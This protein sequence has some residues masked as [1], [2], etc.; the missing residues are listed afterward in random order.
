MLASPVIDH[1]LA[2]VSFGRVLFPTDFSPCSERALTYLLQVAERYRSHVFILHVLHAA[3][4]GAS[5]TVTDFAPHLFEINRYDAEKHIRAL[6]N[7]GALAEVEHS[8]LLES[9][10]LRDVLEDTIRRHD[11]DLVVIGSHGRGGI[12]KLFLGSVAEEVSRTARCAVLMVGPRVLPAA[13]EFTFRHI[14][15]ATEFSSGSLHA[16]R[17]ALSMAQHYGAD[18]TLLHVCSFIEGGPFVD[19]NAVLE[20]ERE[21]LGTLVPED[22]DLAK[23]PNLIARIGITPDTILKIAGEITADLIVMGVRPTHALTLATHVPWPVAHQ[24]VCHAKCP[25]LT[26][27]G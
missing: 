24:V 27:G 20:Q 9:G 26:V 4:P 19:N 11:I 1:A 8:I 2:P 3:S 7:S 10:A 21:R 18:L 15:Y 6:E 22:V 25:V 5:A 16:L 12:R 14:L 13:T 17:Y 23:P